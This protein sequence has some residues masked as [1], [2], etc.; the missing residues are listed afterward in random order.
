ME[1][2]RE[3]GSFLLCAN[4]PDESNYPVAWITTKDLTGGPL[5]TV[6]VDWIGFACTTKKTSLQ[7]GLVKAFSKDTGGRV[8][9]RT[10]E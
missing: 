10:P 4:V 7:K 2:A 5:D 6:V 9:G 3:V 8:F 1:V